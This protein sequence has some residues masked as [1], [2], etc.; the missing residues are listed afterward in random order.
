[1]TERELFEQWYCRKY[2]VDLIARV[3]RLHV[4]GRGRYSNRG[5]QVRW[6]TWQEARSF[7]QEAA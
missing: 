2:S 5:V 4:N 6:E 7:S 1:M 3:T